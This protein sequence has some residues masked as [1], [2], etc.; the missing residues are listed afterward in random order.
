MPFLNEYGQEDMNIFLQSYIKQHDKMYESKTEESE[1]GLC[2]I[3]K[4]I[5][6][7]FTGECS[8]C[9]LE[10]NFILSEFCY[11]IKSKTNVYGMG[12]EVIEGFMIAYKTAMHSPT[13]EYTY[14]TYCKCDICSYITSNHPVE[15]IYGFKRGCDCCLCTNESQVQDKLY[16]INNMKRELEEYIEDKCDIKYE[17][18]ITYILTN[19][20]V[21]E[22]IDKEFIDT[23]CDVFI[24]KLLE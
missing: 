21:N 23:Y 19:I 4:L 5:E 17:H 9:S 16:V 14:H 12:E 2:Y 11:D 8:D 18:I 10:D 24:Y 3:I 15:I 20:D 22:N 6:R 7:M 13:K 1:N